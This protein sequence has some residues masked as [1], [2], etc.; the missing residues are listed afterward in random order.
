MT[1]ETVV[2]IV[3]DGPKPKAKNG[4]IPDFKSLSEFKAWLTPERRKNKAVVSY[5]EKL[6]AKLQKG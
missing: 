1:D 2:K 4:G 3:E 5:S 6:I